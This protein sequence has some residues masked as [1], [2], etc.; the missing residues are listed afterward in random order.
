MPRV[1]LNAINKALAAAGHEERLVK[2]NGYFYFDGPALQWYDHSVMTSWLGTMTTA[3]WVEERDRL[4]AAD[5]RRRG[6]D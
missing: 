1:T 4:A 6:E 2:G 3:E 5:R